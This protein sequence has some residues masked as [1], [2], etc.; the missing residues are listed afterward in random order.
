MSYRILVL[1]GYGV[2]GSRVCRLLA[3]LNGLELFV[4]GRSHFAAEKLCAQI[5]AETPEA[6]VQPFAL[7]LTRDL[8][9]ALEAT[10]PRLVIHAA[11]PFQGQDYT[12]AS[13]C[14]AQGVHYV[15]LADGREFV[16]NFAQLNPAAQ[17]AGVIAIS[18]A[19][20]VPGLSAAVADHLKSSF[21]R[22]DS[23]ETGITPGNRAPRGRAVVGAI[24]SYVGRPMRIWRG[25]KW[26]TVCGWQGLRRRR[27]R[28]IGDIVLP[29]RWFA[30][31]DVPDLELLPAR[32]PGTQTVEFRAGLELAALHLGLW[33][34]S[35]P[36]R[37][38]L[39]PRLSRFTGLAMFVGERLKRAGTDRGGMYVELRGEGTDG[40]PLRRVWTLIAE[41][42]KGPW[43]P[44]IPATIIAI[45]LAHGRLSQTGAMPCLGL[46]TLKEFHDALP[47]L[48]ISTSIADDRP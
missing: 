29:P 9:S 47:G 48:E 13:A 2:F 7:D 46:F 22:L 25:G 33:L 11:G 23:V 45:K 31:C 40:A 4:A 37:F 24:L 18:G 41:A 26:T 1:G 12:V 10:G 21:A 5:R 15:D 42:G 8:R 36:V 16:V 28:L 35:W 34:L 14:I 38:R 44:A 17:R 6:A 19:S 3:R 30:R 43:I 20:S 39:L 32:Y 27:L